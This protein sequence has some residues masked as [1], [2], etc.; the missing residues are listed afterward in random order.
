MI[1]LFLFLRIPIG[2]FFCRDY[3]HFAMSKNATYCRAFCR[4]GIASHF[5]SNS[6]SIE[7][8]HEDA[9]GVKSMED[10]KFPRNTF[11]LW[12][13]DLDCGFEEWPFRRITWT[14]TKIDNIKTK[15]EDEEMNKRRSTAKNFD[16]KNYSTEKRLLLLPT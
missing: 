15:L 13:L 8:G 10:T 9:H 11:Q 3:N 2:F 5:L 7:Q 4:D 12:P 6:T 14:G 1:G 16:G